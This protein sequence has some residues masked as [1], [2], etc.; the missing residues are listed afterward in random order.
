MKKPRNT[1]LSEKL[2]N[3]TQD[4]ILTNTLH[5]TNKKPKCYLFPAGTFMYEDKYRERLHA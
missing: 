1:L 2:Q 5:Q 4:T 3:D